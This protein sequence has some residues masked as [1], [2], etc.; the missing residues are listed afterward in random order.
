MRL[1]SPEAREELAM[2]AQQGVGLDDK[3]GRS[4]GTKTAGK[5]YQERAISRRAAWA[6]DAPLQDDELLPEECILEDECRL[7][8]QQI[9]QAP[10]QEGDGSR[11][12]GNVQMPTEDLPDAAAHSGKTPEEVGEH[13]GPSQCGLRLSAVRLDCDP[14]LQP[15]CTSGDIRADVLIGQDS[16]ETACPRGTIHLNHG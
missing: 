8:T 14:S 11:F 15:P 10:D 4:P 12:R 3:Q 6:L 5:Q 2:P 16:R 9:G 13:G 1:S 7:T